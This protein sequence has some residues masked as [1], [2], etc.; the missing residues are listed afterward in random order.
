MPYS[1]ALV[2]TLAAD[3]ATK[4]WALSLLVEP[5]RITDWLYL[6]LHLN[7]GMYLGVAPVTGAFE[8]LYLAVMAFIAVWLVK[9][10]V[11]TRGWWARAGWSLC[12]A[13]AIGNGLW[14]LFGPVPD[15][16]GI[17]PVVPPHQWLFFNLADVFLVAGFFLLGGVLLKSRSICQRPS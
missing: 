11:K 6:A 12:A 3:V 17:G 10:A 2:V 8:L 14:R 9:N 4:V 5:V 7:E 13:G 16:I 15:F 1:A